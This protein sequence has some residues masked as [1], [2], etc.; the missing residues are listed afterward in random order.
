MT[1]ESQR[2]GA[3]HRMKFAGLKQSL[4]GL[5]PAERI[6][7]ELRIARDMGLA[8]SAT[9]AASIGRPMQNRFRA[10]AAL[11]RAAEIAPVCGARAPDNGQS[12]DLSMRRSA[13]QALLSSAFTPALQAGDV[14]EL[15]K[16]LRGAADLESAVVRMSAQLELISARGDQQDLAREA[17][18]AIEH[19]IF[20]GADPVKSR[21]GIGG[22]ANS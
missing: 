9:E 3:E 17:I 4:S 10:D 2:P 18:L 11:M 19:T 20:A 14:R 7:Q 21:R 5:P 16:S 22:E 12:A 8:V 13:A 15:A 1:S 6:A